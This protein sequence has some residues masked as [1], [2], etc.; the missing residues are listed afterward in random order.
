[1]EQFEHYILTR[2]NIARSFGKKVRDKKADLPQ[3]NLDESYLEQ[4][5]EMFEKYTFPSLQM[6]TNQSFKW[7]VFFHADT[8][9]K[10]KIKIRDYQKRMP[11]FIPI[12]L[13]EEQSMTS[14][15]GE[16]E[17]A[18][19]AYIQENCQTEWVLTSRI[20]NDDIYDKSYVETVQNYIKTHEKE[21]YILSLSYGLQYDIRKNLL[22]QYKRVTNHFI[23]LFSPVGEQM[24][25]INWMNHGKLRQYQI[26]IDHYD[27]KTPKWVELV[28]ETNQKNDTRYAFANIIWNRDLLAQYSIIPLQTRGAYAKYLLKCIPPALVG[29][30][31]ELARKVYRKLKHKVY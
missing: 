15:G 2:F 25:H 20:D 31:E 27:D 29:L 30:P 12:F 22:L 8:P 26:D 24:N 18:V 14:E 9:E 28:H 4:R 17:K 21:R 3:K 7:L 1:M 16:S 19:T 5:F 11:S 23:S 6:Q 10:F 13:T